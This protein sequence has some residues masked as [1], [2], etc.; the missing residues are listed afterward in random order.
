MISY[1]G[2]QTQE[3]AIKPSVKVTMRSNA[4]ALDEVVVGGCMGIKN[5]MYFHLVLFLWP[6]C[7]GGFPEGW[8]LCT[9]HPLG[10]PNTRTDFYYIYKA[11]F[12]PYL[13]RIAAIF[14]NT[15]VRTDL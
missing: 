4:E 14:R 11:I 13:V 12:R 5:C 10:Y 1:I 15:E 8:G 9:P 7:W 6:T 3:V 2:M